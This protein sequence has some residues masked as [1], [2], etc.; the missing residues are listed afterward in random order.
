MRKLPDFGW[1]SGNFLLQSKAFSCAICLV[2]GCKMPYFALYSA[3]SFIFFAC[4][5]GNPEHPHAIVKRSLRKISALFWNHND[6]RTAIYVSLCQM[7]TDGL[8]QVFLSKHYILFVYL[9]QSN[10]F[11][12]VNRGDPPTFTFDFLRIFFV[13][14]TSSYILTLGKKQINLLFCSRLI[15]I[16]VIFAKTL[17]Y[18]MKACLFCSFIR[19]TDGKY[20]Y[21]DYI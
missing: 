12:T 6:T 16:F 8:I 15:R 14:L 19:N 18:F 1:K 21:T 3:A 11:A 17:Q 20:H 5:S 2:L 4:L 13:Y 7:S 9:H 10:R